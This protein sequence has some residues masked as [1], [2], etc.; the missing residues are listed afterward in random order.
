M[1]RRQW[2]KIGGQILLGL[3]LVIHGLSYLFSLVSR[4]LYEPSRRFKVGKPE[5]LA[6]GVTFLADRRVFLIKKGREIRAI[7][8]VCTH[9]GCTVQL[10]NLPAPK[11]IKVR[12]K[13]RT[14]QWEFHC[15]CH[16]SKFYGNGIPYAG[17]AP[18]NLPWFELSISPADGQIVVNSAK[19]VGEDFSLKV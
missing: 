17:P 18:K 7:S 1:N 14:F 10:V 5:D 11:R 6:E 12:G 19:E 9:L 16:G 3:G 8:A 4:A 2:F 15:P 13:F